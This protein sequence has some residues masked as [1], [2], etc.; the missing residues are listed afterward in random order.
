MPRLLV[1][2][3][4]CSY[5]NAHHSWYEPRCTWAVSFLP[6]ALLA[7]RGPRCAPQCGARLHLC[8][9]IGGS[10]SVPS[11][12]SLIAGCACIYAVLAPRGLRW[13]CGAGAARWL[14]RRRTPSCSPRAV[15]HH[16]AA[17]LLIDWRA[18]CLLYCAELATVHQPIIS[19]AH[20][21]VSNALVGIICR[22]WTASQPTDAAG[23]RCTAG[24]G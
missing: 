15:A 21:T 7:R 11:P 3:G 16:S 8:A 19:I 4:A 18:P 12:C 23:T 22:R 24:T 10:A 14:S 2:G 6:I 20:W 13:Y 17:T 1:A 5:A 9:V